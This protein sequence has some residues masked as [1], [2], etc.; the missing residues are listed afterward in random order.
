MY[1]NPNAMNPNIGQPRFQSI[2]NP[3][4]KLSGR[5]GYGQFNI[6]RINPGTGLPVPTQTT[7]LLGYQRGGV[8]NG[9][10]DSL[11]Q[12]GKKQY[13][14]P[15]SGL[16]TELSDSEIEMYVKGGYIIEDE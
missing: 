13:G 9:L 12:L 1:G 6:N 7:N 3:I 5:L 11:R 8:S 16:A 4:N 14:G 2:T 10:I 15:S